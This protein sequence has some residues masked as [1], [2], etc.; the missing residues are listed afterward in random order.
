MNPEPLPKRN[1]FKL[2]MDNRFA[3]LVAMT[4]AR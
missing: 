1:G 2:V 4:G 3:S